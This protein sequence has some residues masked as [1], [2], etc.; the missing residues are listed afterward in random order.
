MIEDRLPCRREFVVPRD[1]TLRD[2]A[3]R[4]SKGRTDQ[5]KTREGEEKKTLRRLRG[6]LSEVSVGKLVL[7]Q[8]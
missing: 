2:D 6:G 4:V 3:K 5:E 7:I 8:L 1:Q